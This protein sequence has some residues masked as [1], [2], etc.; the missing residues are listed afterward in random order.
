MLV[1]GNAACPCVM[2][3]RLLTL[4]ED[5]LQ[6]PHCPQQQSGDLVP[7]GRRGGKGN[8]VLGKGTAPS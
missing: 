1:L 4:G 7:T 3:L 5:G 6:T 2:S 8:T